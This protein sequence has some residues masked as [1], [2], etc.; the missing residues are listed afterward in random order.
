MESIHKR[1]WKPKENTKEEPMATNGESFLGPIKN[2]S[3]DR[4]QKGD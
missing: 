4:P 1:G 3:V 2:G